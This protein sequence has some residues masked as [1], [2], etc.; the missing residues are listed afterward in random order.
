MKHSRRFVVSG[1]PYTLLYILYWIFSGS[2]SG[3]QNVNR[4]VQNDNA[5]DQ[6][7][8][9]LRI[10]DIPGFI[11]L[12]GD[13]HIHTSFSDGYV[14]PDFRITEAWTE[15]LD[16]IAITDHIESR[17]HKTD[18]SDDQNSG[19]QRALARANAL[20]ILLVPGA[21][22]SKKIPP[23]HL[24][25]LFVQDVNK[26]TDNDPMVQIEEAVKQGGFI[27]WNHPGWGW[28][29]PLPD[30]TTWWD[31]QTAILEKGWLHGIEVYNTEEWYQ[32]ALRWCME[33]NLTVFAN[34]DIHAPVNYWYN[35]SLPN[36][37]R[38]MTLVFVKEKSLNG[39]KEALFAKR[40][41]G[42]FDDILAGR[43]D[44]VKELF[45]ASVTFNPPFRQAGKAGSRTFTAELENHS[46][47]TFILKKEGKAI[48]ND[49]SDIVK[50][51]PESLAI[52]N[53]RE[54]ED[55]LPF[56]LTN[57]YSDINTHPLVLLPVIKK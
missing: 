16:V 31:F 4:A 51:S 12:K 22:I 41:L 17:P 56:R 15:G 54:T 25:A 20:N 43:E 53:Y 24:N 48:H 57:C 47:L 35:L 52:I 21:E 6:N 30:T 14:W 34:S 38:P 29:S 2:L 3:A 39:V 44:L 50:L 19:Y 32:I 11:T 46:D 13:F 27:L 10:P 55:V 36:S 5:M 23:G 37:H 26:L 18:S 1:V 33:K 9:I 28:A 8:K 42:Y 49:R 45:Y 40:T 7:R